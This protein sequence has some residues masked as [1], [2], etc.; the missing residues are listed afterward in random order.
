MI[1]L[2]GWG[3]SDA[4]P[5]SVIELYN[6]QAATFMH[7]ERYGECDTSEAYGK[8]DQAARGQAER[9]WESIYTRWLRENTEERQN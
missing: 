5:A 6:L 8:G 2:G 9:D 3:L 1:T 7:E 4:T